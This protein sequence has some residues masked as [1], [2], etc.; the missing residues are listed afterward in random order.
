MKWIFFLISG[1]TF[2]LQAQRPPIPELP[3]DHFA[4]PIEHAPR[5]SGNFGELRDNHFHAGLDFKSSR[6]L[7]GDRIFSVD[8][9]FVSRI[10]INRGGYGKTLY[11]DH[12]CGLTSVYAHLSELRP[13]IDRYV[14][15]MQRIRMNFE[16]DLQ[17]DSTSLRVARGEYIGQMGNSGHSYGPHLH[18]ELRDTE[19]EIPIN[20]LIYG[21][22]IDDTKAPVIRDLFIYTLDNRLTPLGTYHVPLKKVGSD[23]TSQVDTLEVNGWRCGIGVDAY[24]SQNGSYNKNGIYSM[25]LFVD[26]S[27]HFRFS[28]RH[29]SFDETRQM[30]AHIDYRRRQRHRQ[31]VHR[32]HILP[33]NE[34]SMYDDVG[35]GVIPVHSDKAVPIQLDVE[36]LHGNKTSVRLIIKQVNEVTEQEKQRVYHALFRYDKTNYYNTSYV[37]VYCPEDAVFCDLPMT[38][39]P[40]TDSSG[41]LD[42]VRIGYPDQPLRN[43]L[44]VNLKDELLR[45]D[46]KPKACLIYKEHRSNQ[47]KS[48]GSHPSDHG[49]ECVLPY[50]GLYEL[51]YDTLPPTI[52]PRFS[53]S[54]WRDGE[55]MEWELKDNY[56]VIGEAQEV[57]I[58]SLVGNSFTPGYYDLK[59]HTFTL[60]IQKIWPRGE[61]EITIR[62]MDDRNNLAE[63]KRTVTIE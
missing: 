9:G 23:W 6:G 34:L 10:K 3:Q 46:L 4:M 7:P 8:K 5:L 2:T 50:L 29:C 51:E 45:M 21:F 49:I 32:A 57:R 13:D 55:V 60:A 31:F 62:A 36:D 28:S 17:L 39:E 33:N 24:D 25:S 11:V 12:P 59:S 37:S 19:S 22:G 54:I 56:E 43:N 41:H 27:L 30:N 16:V 48:V 20:P 35:H 40:K 18:F 14:D 38:V 47:E 26:D 52:R 15:S 63:W 61:Q 42:Q 53:K 1:I 44:I 58:Q